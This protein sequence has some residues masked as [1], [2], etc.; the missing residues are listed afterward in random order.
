MLRLLHLH[1]TN[2]GTLH[3]NKRASVHVETKDW[4]TCEHPF[5]S[6]LQ[7]PW[8]H[9]FFLTYLWLQRGLYGHVCHTTARCSEW[10]GNFN[11]WMEKPSV[12]HVR[13]NPLVLRMWPWKL[14]NW[15]K[16]SEKMLVKLCK[17]VLAEYFC[18]I[19]WGW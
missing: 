2:W 19:C 5:R 7:A 17:V 12:L 6:N 16:K 4:S 9:E 8:G 3:P 10:H 18:T 14:K 11:T 1:I 13:A 15:M